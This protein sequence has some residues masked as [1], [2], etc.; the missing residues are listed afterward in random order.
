MATNFNKRIDNYHTYLPA[1][2]YVKAL[3][4]EPSLLRNGLPINQYFM[5]I[6]KE[7]FNDIVRQGGE[8]I[9]SYI[10]K[11]N[12]GE[13]EWIFCSENMIE[14]AFRRAFDK[15]EGKNTTLQIE[16]NLK[17]DLDKLLPSLKKESVFIG[18][19]YL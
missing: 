14:T 12:A 19:I 18:E 8:P 2:L 11:F 6:E 17:A 5:K 1:G 4:S 16:F 9:Q 7:I 13:T 3:L 10:R 15:Y